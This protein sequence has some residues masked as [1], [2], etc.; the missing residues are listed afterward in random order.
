[1]I[2]FSQSYP[3]AIPLLVVTFVLLVFGSGAWLVW[4]QSKRLWPSNRGLSIVLAIIGFGI[5]GVGAWAV[6]VISAVF[7]ISFYGY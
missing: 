3:W 7:K 2:E 5:A 4:Y 6:V 1:M